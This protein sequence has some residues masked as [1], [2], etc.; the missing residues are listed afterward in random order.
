M[1]FQPDSMQT[2]LLWSLLFKHEGTALLK[3]IKPKLQKAKGLTGSQ[4]REQLVE[5]GLIDKE[6]IGKRPTILTLTD[7]GWAWAQKNMVSELSS[8]SPASGPVLQA[9]LTRLGTFMEHNE[10]SLA[11]LFIEQT[12]EDS[13][14]QKNQEIDLKTRIRDYWQKI[15]GGRR[16][17]QVRLTGLREELKD[18]DQQLLDSTITDMHSTGQLILSPLEDPR[19]V[20]NIDKKAAISIAGEANHVFFME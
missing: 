19:D 10:I 7:S 15:T 14:P 17:L 6:K 8:K 9:L 2:L 13:P 20:T 5:A 11:E 1:S 12:Q 4:R 16:D 3:D 18:I